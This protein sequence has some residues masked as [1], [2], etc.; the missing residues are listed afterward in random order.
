M[1]A[2]F[3][4][5]KKRYH[6]DV[7]SDINDITE[8][9]ILLANKKGSHD[10]IEEIAIAWRCV[11]HNKTGDQFL[12]LIQVIFYHLAIGCT[13]PIVLM[14]LNHVSVFHFVFC[15]V[16]CIEYNSTNRKSPL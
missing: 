1:N 11:L 5:L 7:I 6:N 8:H 2:H 4:S 9:W 3:L 15:F 16:L 13:T 14:R 12:P 10:V